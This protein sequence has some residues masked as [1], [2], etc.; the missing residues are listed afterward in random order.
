MWNYNQIKLKI[1]NKH[2]L[3]IKELVS[4]LHC[5]GTYGLVE[6][7]L[8]E[9]EKLIDKD[10]TKKMDIKIG[11]K[12][13]KQHNSLDKDYWKSYEVV[14]S[15]YGLDGGSFPEWK[16]REDVLELKK[17]VQVIDLPYPNS[18]GLE[19]LCEDMTSSQLSITWMPLKE[20]N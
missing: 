10:K 3:K 17:Y 1:M 13:S 7:E 8:T 6:L 2:I 14:G 9:L 16:T 15:S 18:N 19:G 4:D 5:M 12:F 11:F 20:F